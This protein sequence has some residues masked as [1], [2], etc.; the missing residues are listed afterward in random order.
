MLSWFAR[1]GMFELRTVRATVYLN[2]RTLIVLQFLLL[3]IVVVEAQDG[4]L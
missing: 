1:N 4:T 3:L 2:E